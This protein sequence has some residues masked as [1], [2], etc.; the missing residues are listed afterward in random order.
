MKI[1]VNKLISK[2]EEAREKNGGNKLVW[3]WYYSDSSADDRLNDFEFSDSTM[4]EI[5]NNL[6]EDG[7]SFQIE[8]K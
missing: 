3:L 2:L 6:V 8:K 5:E 1:T 7:I 4:D